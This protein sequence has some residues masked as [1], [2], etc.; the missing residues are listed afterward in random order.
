MGAIGAFWPSL[1]FRPGLALGLK[2][3]RR[4]QP[5]LHGRVVTVQG[6]PDIIQVPCWPQDGEEGVAVPFQLG[7]LVPAQGVFDGEFVQVAIEPRP[8]RSS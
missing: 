3:F 5:D 7:P 1:G 4:S 6:G 2:N 8:K